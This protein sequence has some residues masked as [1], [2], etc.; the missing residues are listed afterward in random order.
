MTISSTTNRATFTGNGVTTSFSFPY[1]V[2]AAAD[3]KVYQEGT[4][5]TL[6]THYTLSGTA[7]YTSG[8]NVQFVTAPASGDEIVILR[9]PDPTQAVE[10]TENDPLPV[11]TGVERPLDK[12]TMVTQRLKDRVDRS[13]RQP[14]TDTAALAELPVAAS[15]ANKYPVFDANGQ[16]TV[17][18]GTGADDGLRGDLATTS[19]SLGAELVGYIGSSANAVAGTVRSAIR[20]RRRSVFEFFSAAQKAD[21]RAGTG[22]VDVTTALQTAINELGNTDAIR[23][24]GYDFPDGVYVVEETI[25]ADRKAVMLYG[26]GVGNSSS[27]GGSIF[28]WQ[29]VAGS[30]IL[31]LKRNLMTEIHGFRFHGNSSAIPSAAIDLVSTAAESGPNTRIKLSHLWVGG[32]SGDVD[33][34]VH[35]ADGIEVSG[36]NLQ[37]DQSWMTDLMVTSFSGAGIRFGNGQNVLWTIAN[38]TI[39]GAQN[40]SIGVSTAARHVKLDN[41]FFQ[42]NKLTDIEITND[43]TIDAYQI[44]SELSGRLALATA[45][46]QLRIRGGYWQSGV[47]T[48]ADDNVIDISGGPSVVRIEDFQFDRAGSYVGAGET[49]KMRGASAIA[50]LHNVSL[51][52]DPATFFDM[53]TVTAGD[54]RRVEFLGGNSSDTLRY[55]VN[56]WNHGESPDISGVRVDLPAHTRIRQATGNTTILEVVSSTL[57]TTYLTVSNSGTTFGDDATFTAGKLS[58]AASG[59]SKSGFRLP[60]GTAP[61]SPVDGDMWTTTAGLFVRINGATVGPLS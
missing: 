10:H 39:N 23:S 7:P 28:K 59:T 3:L 26:R 40:T 50:S 19:A 36:D 41:V 17:S 1:Y 12:L 45:G 27:T 14:D 35:F 25:E 8:T 52:V 29:G 53:A 20:D 31:R 34:G 32:F 49:L 18:T 21:V 30:P 33:T 43:G 22:L 42:T 5:K 6:T 46:A 55:F 57:A 13:V 38:A 24:G 37:G 60:H 15:R 11:K 44:G 51:P 9:D 48:N 2:I 47:N 16:L 54:Q 58:T 61:T 56:E 4:L